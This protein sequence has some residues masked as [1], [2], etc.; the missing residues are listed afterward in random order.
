[1]T[2]I[3]ER[4]KRDLGDEAREETCR[5]DRTD[6]AFADAVAVPVFGEHGEHHAVARRHEARC[7]EQDELDSP[8]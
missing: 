2:S 8:T 5:D 4:G 3:G 1:M 7:S 6:A